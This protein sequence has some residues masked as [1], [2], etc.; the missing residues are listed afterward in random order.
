MK[1]NRFLG[2]V[3][4]GFVLL[5][6]NLMAQSGYE[7]KTLLGGRHFIAL[8][9][10]GFY[11]APAYGLTR[12]DGSTASLLHLRSGINFKDKFSLGGYY[13]RSINQIIPQSETLNNVYLDYWT[14]GGFVEYTLLSKKVVHFTF[15]LFAGYG[16]VEMDNEMGDAGL[17]ETNFVQIEPSA[18]LEVNVHRH[19]RFNL[20]AGY[21]WVGPMNYRNFD[22]TDMSGL[23]GYVGLK[24]GLFR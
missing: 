9:D 4:V 2:F 10:A 8:K 24:F 19:V 17:G 7:A 12:I 6:N 22:R 14:V 11:V 15:P 23:V 16:E 20:G 13:N 18:L 3:F 1:R 5:H 21:R